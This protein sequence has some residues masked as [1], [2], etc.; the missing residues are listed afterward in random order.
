MPPSIW[1]LYWN[2]KMC[3]EGEINILDHRLPSATRRSAKRY[4][5]FPCSRV[6]QTEAH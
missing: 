5:L 4:D 6:G 3:K 1:S 2:N